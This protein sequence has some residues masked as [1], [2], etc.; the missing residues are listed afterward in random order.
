MTSNS[1]TDFLP[2]AQAN[3]FLPPISRWMTFGGLIIVG[4]LG[5]AIAVTA[6]VKYKVTVKGQA[7][8]RPAGELRLV[9]AATEGSVM[10]IAVKVH[11]QVE[12]GDVIATIDDF[13]LQTKKSQLQSSIQQAQLQQMQINAQISALDSQIRAETDRMNSGVAAATAELNGRQRE[14][15]D[16]R[17]TGVAEFAEAEATV[18]AVEAALGAA[19]SKNNRY[20][21]IAETGAISTDQLEEV[22]LE[23]EQQEQSLEATQAALQNAQAALNPTDAAVTI[24]AEQMVQEKAS[25]QAKLATLTKEREA[26]IQQRIEIDK[27]LEHDT[28]ELQQVVFELRQTTITATADGVVTKLNLRNSNQVVHS[29]EQIAE[30]VPSNAPLEVKAAISPQDIDKVKAGQ[31]AQMRVSACPYPDYGVLNGIVSQISEDTIKPQVDE[32]ATA[33]TV[34]N[35]NENATPAFYEV[36]IEP[37]HLSLNQSKNQCSLQPGMEGRV[38]IVTR[39][40]T[41]LQFLLRKARLIA[42]V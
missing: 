9:Q 7:S 35:Q 2:P 38:D 6:V 40:E 15:Q 5:A 17:V 19:R 1:N 18:R 13:Q 23:V 30:I 34:S 11:Q 37:E 42:D 16:Q 10:H 24:A 33:P 22:Q 27:Q 39:E 21:S 31:N 8:V 20:H 26:L 28:R 4:V 36:T 41:V 32:T 12:Q 29:G 3:E 14:Y 25:G